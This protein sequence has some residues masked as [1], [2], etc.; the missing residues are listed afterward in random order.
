VIVRLRGTYDYSNRVEF[1]CAPSPTIYSGKN[2]NLA[3]REDNT[4][5]ANCYKVGDSARAARF[6]RNTSA[7]GSWPEQS[8]MLRRR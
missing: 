6:A 5:A 2:E 7:G 4:V 3:Q 8:P 1:L